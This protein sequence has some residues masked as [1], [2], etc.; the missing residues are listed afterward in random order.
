MYGVGPTSNEGFAPALQGLEKSFDYKKVLKAFKKG[1]FVLRSS[2]CSLH[3]SCV[4]FVYNFQ[5]MDLRILPFT[6]AR[7]QASLVYV[8]CQQHLCVIRIACSACAS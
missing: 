1:E 3:S 4:R 5:Q 8:L 7:D 6:E 2:C